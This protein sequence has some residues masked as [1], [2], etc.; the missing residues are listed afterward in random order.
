MDPGQWREAQAAVND[1]LAGEDIAYFDLLASPAFVDEDF[2]DADHLS[3]A[4]RR[5]LSLM[6]DSLI[7]P[8]Q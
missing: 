4:G 8:N 6:L 5:K 3:A 2:R 7:K 1:V